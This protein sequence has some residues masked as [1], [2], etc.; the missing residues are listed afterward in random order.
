MTPIGRI[1]NDFSEEAVE[2]LATADIPASLVFSDSF[3]SEKQR[4]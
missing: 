1:R 2:H 3:S 4:I